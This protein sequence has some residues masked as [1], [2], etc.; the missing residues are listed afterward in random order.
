[1]HINTLTAHYSHD[2]SVLH[3]GVALRAETCRGSNSMNEVVLTYVHYRFY[4]T[5]L[6]LVH[7]YGQ[8]KASYLYSG[9]ASCKSWLS[10]VVFS[11]IF[12]SPYRHRA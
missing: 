5:N 1:M 2:V 3:E 7:G 11:V 10:C 8:D 9:D 12:Y 4:I 6:S